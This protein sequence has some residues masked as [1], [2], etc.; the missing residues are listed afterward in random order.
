V[1]RRMTV[2]GLF[3]GLI[4]LGACA[5]SSAPLPTPKA[6]RTPKPTF[7]VV[8]GSATPVAM[9]SPSA[10]GGGTAVP[11]ATRAVE[12]IP[13][14]G[15]TAAVTP[16]AEVT[17]VATASAE[18]TGALTAVPTATA[19]ARP[20]H[21]PVPT[22]TPLP[23]NTPVPSP[24]PLSCP[25]GY[26]LY[27]HPS[28][29]FK[30]C[31]PAGWSVFDEEDPDESARW[32]TFN[33][34]TSNRDSGEGLKMIVLRVGPNTTGKSGNDFL[35]ASALSLIKEYSDLLLEWPYAI[36]VADHDAVEANYQVA[37][38][39]QSGRIELVGWKAYFLVGN[40]QWMIHAVCRSQYRS[41][42]EGIHDEFL[43]HFLP[44]A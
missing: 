29:A 2:V 38:P 26:D 39:F 30:A 16:S 27:T 42:L 14:A 44:P 3:L 17:A 25:A 13:T 22:N 31:H 41:E 32:V 9:A 33:A 18:A 1:L 23:T 6:T 11:S 20:T 12:T 21:T 28:L 15:R 36:R 37:L 8:A 40:Q 7:T 4:V 35:S 24:T 19:T 43:A 5:P 34:P 10:S